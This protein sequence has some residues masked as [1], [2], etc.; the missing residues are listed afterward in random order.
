MYN[1][2]ITRVAGLDEMLV[3]GFERGVLLSE[4]GYDWV[5]R[6]DF[7]IDQ[8]RFPERGRKKMDVP[9]ITD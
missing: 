6:T 9:K 1:R 7:V 5:R 2:Q 4:M 8:D 3:E